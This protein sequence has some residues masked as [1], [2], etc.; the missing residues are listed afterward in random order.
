MY[1]DFVENWFSHSTARLC[2]GTLQFSE[3]FFYPKFLWLGGGYH[4]FLSKL[5]LSHSTEKIPRGP[6]FQKKSGIKKLHKM[7]YH[8][9]VE[10]WFSH[11]TENFRRG[12]LLFSEKFFYR[13]FLWIGMGYHDFLWKFFCLTVPKNFLGGPFFS[14]IF[15]N[16]EIA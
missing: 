15:W 7:V 8:E 9:F 5:F 4:D 6:F 16:K 10:N 11:S 3:I 2:R 14:E 12:T 1:H 13:K